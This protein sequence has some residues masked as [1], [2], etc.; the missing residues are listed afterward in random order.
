MLNHDPICSCSSC[1]HMDE[2]MRGRSEAEVGADNSDSADGRVKVLEALTSKFTLRPEV[3]LLR[4]ATLCPSNATG[5]DL[6]ALAVAA[7][8]RAVR[9]QFVDGRDV[10]SATQPE[11][12]ACDPTV[13]VLQADLDAAAL[14][15]R[16][17]LS[18]LEV[19]KYQRL[20]TKYQ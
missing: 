12:S 6:Y 8:M 10:V 7:W 16:P 4:V 20:R 1:R 15:L 9:R 11:P 5:A 2:S 3:D 18:E 14:E 17:S 19:A 13:V